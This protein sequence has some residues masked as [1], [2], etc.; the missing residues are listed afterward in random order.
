M[1]LFFL[2][3]SDLI[4]KRVQEFIP[5]LDLQDDCIPIGFCGTCRRK[6]QVAESLSLTNLS[7][8]LATQKRT[9]PRAECKC[10]VCEIASAS[11]LQAKKH[12]KKHTTPKGRSSEKEEEIVHRLCGKC[13]SPLYRGCKH[14]CGSSTMV[15]NFLKQ[16]PIN[17]QK[18]V[19]S[20][21]AK[22]EAIKTGSN[23]IKLTTGGTP[24]SLSIGPQKA[25]NK[26]QI[27]HE[28]LD[29]IQAHANLSGK[30]L[31]KGLK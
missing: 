2:L 27:T 30:Q 22:N 21:V 28:H 3:S 24:L 23:D 19:A 13:Y 14:E 26:L 16:A 6:L 31:L 15:D 18:R 25:E 11:G 7:K 20:T 5:N 17:V 8:F 1:S 10:F 9:S 4:I 29:H 12:Q